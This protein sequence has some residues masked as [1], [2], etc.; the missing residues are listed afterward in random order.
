MKPI[1]DYLASIATA[2]S[3]GDATG[4]IHRP[5]LKTL[6]ESFGKGVTATR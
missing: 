3:K 4:H 1:N 6:I 2:L 5:A